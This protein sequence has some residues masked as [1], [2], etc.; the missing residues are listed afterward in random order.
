MKVT[1]ERHGWTFQAPTQAC[2]EC[3]WHAPNVET[4]ISRTESRG[5]EILEMVCRILSAWP[6]QVHLLAV[7]MRRM[8]V[9]YMLDTARAWQRR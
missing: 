3:L 6:G 9:P 4:N 7:I 8:G 2:P 5:P 1:C